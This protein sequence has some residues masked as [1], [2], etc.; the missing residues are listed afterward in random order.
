MELLPGDILLDGGHNPQ[1][2]RAVRSALEDSG[3]ER[4]TAFIG[5][6]NTKDHRAFLQEILPCFDR[7]YFCDGF[8]E[9]EVPAEELRRI[10]GRDGAEIFDSPREALM[11]ARRDREGG[12]MYF[13]GSF[14]FAAAVREYLVLYQVQI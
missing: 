7:V 3:Y 11:F 5:M 13:C 1:A 4:R 14:Y 8:S 12:L 10:S 9:G 6:L 2:A